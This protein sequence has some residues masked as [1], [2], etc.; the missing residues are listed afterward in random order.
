MPRTSRKSRTQRAGLVFPV[1][2][3]GR[4][5]RGEWQRGTHGGRI[6]VGASVYFAA[7]LE[8]LT[9]EVM[10]LAG[11]FSHNTLKKKRIVPRAIAAITFQ[12]E[13]FQRLLRG[14]IFPDSGSF[15]LHLPTTET[16]GI[17]QKAAS[18]VAAGV[19]TTP[20]KSS[21]GVN[22]KSGQKVGN[23]ISKTKIESSPSITKSPSMVKKGLT[24]K[25]SKGSINV[26]TPAVSNLGCS[27]Q[28]QEGKQWKDY[29]TAAIPVV[30]AAYQ[31]WLKNPFIDVRAVKSGQWK[32]QVDFN[33]K[34]QT[35]VQHDS[36]TSRSI[37]RVPPMREKEAAIEGMKK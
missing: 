18:V 14:S 10:E 11:N 30:E 36:H 26:A 37:R 32:Y 1:A 13:E 22:K 35:N 27:W 28:Y 9:A 12:D 7:V 17:S 24:K 3:I 15:P 21:K 19:S 33:Q 25:P 6:S 8:Y 29:E 23:A 34:T 5:L 20:Q 2:R 4:E 31:D 16:L